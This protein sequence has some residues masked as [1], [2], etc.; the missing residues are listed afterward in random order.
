MNSNFSKTW[1]AEDPIGLKFSPP[2][3]SKSNGDAERQ[4]QR[5][6]DKKMR[7]FI[8]PSSWYSSSS[9]SSPTSPWLSSSPSLSLLPDS[10]RC[11]WHSCKAQ[12][13][14]VRPGRPGKMSHCAPQTW[15]WWRWWWRRWQWWWRYIIVMIM[16][17]RMMRM[18]IIEFTNDIRARFGSPS[19]SFSTSVPIIL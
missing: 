12:R 17:I 8:L 6:S 9:S 7:K 19:I 16:T 1:G 11:C 4:D 2:L 15:R 18:M 3:L 13:Q 10:T 14:E 5:P